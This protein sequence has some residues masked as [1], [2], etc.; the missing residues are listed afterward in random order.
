VRKTIIYNEL[1]INK[2]G[3]VIY[4]MVRGLNKRTRRKRNKEKFSEGRP[5]ISPAVCT[6]FLCPCSE[7]YPRPPF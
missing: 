6:L 4:F 3:K 1:T 5:T 7:P 2:Y